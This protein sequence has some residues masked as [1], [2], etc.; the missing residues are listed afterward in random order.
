MK[1]SQ[2][3]IPDLKCQGYHD[4]EASLMAFEAGTRLRKDETVWENQQDF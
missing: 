1:R 3:C 4:D 2:L